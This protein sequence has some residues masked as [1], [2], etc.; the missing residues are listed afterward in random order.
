MDQRRFLIALVLSFLLLLAYEQLVVRPYRKAPPVPQT[1]GQGTAPDQT[2]PQ[3]EREVAP[4]DRTARPDMPATAG[5]LS[6]PAGDSPVVTV[7]TDLVRATITTLGARL[8]SLEFKQF[9]QTVQPDSPLLDLVSSSQ[10]LPI[11]VELGAGNS[12]AAVVYEAN[13]TTLKLSGAEQGDIVFRG[14]TSDGRSIEKR[15]RFLGN[16]YLFD[17]AASGEAA[18]GSVGLILTPVSEQAPAVAGSRGPSRR[19]AFA[20]AKLIEKTLD[21]LKT[22]FEVIGAGW[23]GFSAQYFAALGMPQSETATAWLAKADGTAI[24]RLD[25]P[26]IEGSARFKVFMGP[27]ERDVLAAAGHQLDRAL[28]FGWFWFI[29]IPLLWGLRALYRDH[30]ATTA[31]RSSC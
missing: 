15:Y 12:D 23:A 9:R 4:A 3:P 19:V 29:A 26:A 7:E 17:V 14:S 20:N 16:S 8:K 24:A 21:A 27:K 30:P 6:A 28:D 31:S 11:T 13:A 10:V 5:V 25:L 22:P 18:K 2:A 1:Q